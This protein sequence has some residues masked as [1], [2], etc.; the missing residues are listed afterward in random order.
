MDSISLTL[1]LINAQHLG[2]HIG[3]QMILNIQKPNFNQLASPAHS[4]AMNT[5]DMPDISQIIA[6]ALGLE[7]PLDVHKLFPISHPNVLIFE[8]HAAIPFNEDG[9][10]IFVV[11]EP[12]PSEPMH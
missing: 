8:S 2:D 6:Q 10:Y 9:E 7:T 5:I 11:D 4:K 3:T 1:A 12:N